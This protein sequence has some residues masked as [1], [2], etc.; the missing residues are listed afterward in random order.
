MLINYKVTNFCSFY[1]EAEFSLEA[2]KGKVKSRFPDNYA[3]YENECNVLK[4]AVIVGE[5]AGGKSNF[6]NSILFLKTL[7]LN[8]APVKAVDGYINTTY[9]EKERKEVPQSFVF[10]IVAANEH[11]YKYELSI[12][13][14]RIL[15]ESLSVAESKKRNFVLKMHIYWNEEQ[16]EYAFDL[17]SETKEIQDAM[18]KN[19]GMF[20]LFV[21]RYSLLGNE[22]ASMVTEWVTNKLSPTSFQM[23]ATNDARSN[24]KDIEILNDKRY[25][26]IF[27]MVDYSICRVSVDK[28]Q[29]YAKTMIIRKRKDGSTIGRELQLDST[30]VREFFA[31]AVHIFRVVYEEQTVFADEMDR[32]LN[33]ILSDRVISFV[34]GKTHRGQFV[35]STH[36]VLHLNL[37]TYMKEQIYFITK[38]HDD[39]SSELYSLSDFPEVRYDSTKIYEFYM[40]GILGGTA[41]E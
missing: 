36:N 30:G 12:N 3:N 17:P 32:V 24:Q 8:N 31:W 2:P 27:R 23:T 28:E 41:F 18:K 39:L 22:D 4:S 40:K 35:F 5:N 16:R 33:P 1:N 11:I 20:G 37:T 15:E 26:D 9:S 34:N 7:F 21:T 6:I 29:P 13:Q 25:L 38:V 10:E 14:F 19:A